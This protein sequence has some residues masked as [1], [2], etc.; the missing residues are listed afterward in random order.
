MVVIGAFFLLVGVS[1]FIVF[2]EEKVIMLA[3]LF[4]GMV[5]ASIGLVSLFI[6][7]R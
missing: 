6:I 4:A 5:L 1:E 3:V 2:E 7:N